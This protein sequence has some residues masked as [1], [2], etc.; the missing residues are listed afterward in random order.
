MIN[1]IYDVQFEEELV[2]KT[3]TITLNANEQDD[4]YS[5]VELFALKDTLGNTFWL[6]HTSN[7][8]EMTLKITDTISSINCLP[9][10]PV[11]KD[12]IRY[13]YNLKPLGA[14]NDGTY[15]NVSFTYT[16]GENRKYEMSF[17]ILVK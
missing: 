15:V 3:K 6:N 7:N 10:T 16:I 12:N 5:F 2:N 17:T 4:G 9:I 14:S 11:L 13:D 8:K 1:L